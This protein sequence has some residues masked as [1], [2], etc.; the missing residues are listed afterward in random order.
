MHGRTDGRTDGQ[1]RERERTLVIIIHV[2][3][4]D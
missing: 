3:F 1:T 2:N 4:V